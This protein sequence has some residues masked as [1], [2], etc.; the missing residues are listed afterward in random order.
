MRRQ[1]AVII[2]GAVAEGVD[3]E[4]ERELRTFA[5]ASGCCV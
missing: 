1:A 2:A 4:L 5:C 3:A